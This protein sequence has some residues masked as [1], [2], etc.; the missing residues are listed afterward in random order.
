M[1]LNSP[2]SRGGQSRGTLF[3]TIGVTAHL[4]LGWGSQ[5]KVFVAI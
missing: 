3:Y 5:G 1:G 4:A 2:V